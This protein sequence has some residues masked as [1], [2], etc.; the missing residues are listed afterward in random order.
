V[1]GALVV[2]RPFGRHKVGDVI[3]SPGAIRDALAGEHAGD[4]V[5]TAGAVVS[6][7]KPQE[8]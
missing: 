7:P 6:G 8:S 2:V 5:M 1:D 4:V 3:A